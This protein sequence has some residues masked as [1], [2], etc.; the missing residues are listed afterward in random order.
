VTRRVDQRFTEVAAWPEMRSEYAWLPPHD[1]VT[2]TGAH[3][4]GVS[5]SQHCDAVVDVA[6]RV[7]EIDVPA[8]AVFVTGREPLVWARV[9]EAT[10]AVELY[11][12]PVL[13]GELAA[14]SGR[15]MAEVEIEPALAARDAVVLGI[16][17]VLKRVHVTGGWLSDVAVSTLSY[18]LAWHLLTAYCGVRVAERMRR[19]GLLS[20]RSVD[21]VADLIDAE[22]SGPLPLGRLAN[23]ASLSPY[24]FARAFKAST[25]L[26]PHQFVTMRRVERAK[27]LLM[28][29]HASVTD[30]AHTVGFSNISHFRRVF[31]QHTGWMPGDLR[32]PRTRTVSRSGVGRRQPRGR[33][34]G[35]SVLTPPGRR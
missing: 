18:R 25:G 16:A 1:G 23:A 11:P 17:A 6:G 21:R 35:G 4:V 22:L 32:T 13:L 12:D 29:T 2:V 20:R 5:F 15:S 8:G 34:Q 30:V 31:R 7:S 33:G 9:R 10:D 28:A 14:L 3:Q 27:T 26:A 19:P 24:H